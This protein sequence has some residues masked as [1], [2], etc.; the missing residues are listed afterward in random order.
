MTPF[1]LYVARAGLYLDL[2]YAF[3]LLVMR[4][5]TFFRLNRVLLLAGSYLCLILPLFRIRTVSA[6]G[7]ASDLTMV[8]GGVAPQDPV[9]EAYAFPWEEVLLYL[10][11]AGAAVTL[12]LYLASAW[13]M[14]RIIRSGKTLERDGCS[15]VL[16]E[17]NA[18][19]FSWGHKIVMSRQE[20]E[21]NP[22]IFT[23]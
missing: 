9:A 11:I 8:A 21:G 1:L 5:T 19:S 22:V 13:K 12:A 23:H 18:P 15:L 3:Y 10:F 6:V 14:G 17:E 20:F 2:F 16:L 7:I 4:R